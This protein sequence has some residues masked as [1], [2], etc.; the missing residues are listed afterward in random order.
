[1]SYCYFEGPPLSVPLGS[2]V[3][4]YQ[5]RWLTPTSELVVRM[6]RATVYE[7][8]AAFCRQ[9]RPQKVCFYRTYALGDVIM[10]L[11]VARLFRRL[12]GLQGPLIIVTGFIPWRAL[13][14]KIDRGDLVPMGDL[15]IARGH[16]RRSYGADVHID[17]D[18]CLEA[19]HRGGDE[20]HTHRLD[21]YGRALG[22]S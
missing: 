6:R 2:E 9:V 18:H 1:M 14:G 3:V 11:P 5:P 17:L 15:M 10:L 7:S 16:G 13:G 19:D 21:L 4:S 22:I 12:L 8:P 20:S